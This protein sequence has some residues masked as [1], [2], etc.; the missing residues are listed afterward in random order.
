MW[1]LS[2]T[3]PITKLGRSLEVTAD[4]CRCQIACSYVLR[5]PRN[6]RVMRFRLLTEITERRRLDIN[7]PMH[8]N[9]RDLEAL[10]RVFD[11]RLKSVQRTISRFGGAGVPNALTI[12]IDKA[13]SQNRESVLT[14]DLSFISS[15]LLYQV[16]LIRPISTISH[17]VSPW[18]EFPSWTSL[19]HLSQ[20]SQAGKAY[21][22]SE[23]TSCESSSPEL[24]Q[25]LT[26]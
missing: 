21:E 25:C 16:I 9:R 1:D 10:T 4:F 7:H 8:R 5:I 17:L 18:S 20:Y 22:C 14:I 3:T 26:N 2:W 6:I 11:Q 19:E 23:Q 13:R 15:F 12:E 24:H